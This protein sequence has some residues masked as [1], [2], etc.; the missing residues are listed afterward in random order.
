MIA[1]TVSVSGY[2]S[3]VS[4]PSKSLMILRNDH[5][6]LGGEFLSSRTPI[7]NQLLPDPGWFPEPIFGAFVMQ[8][9]LRLIIPPPVGKDNENNVLI[10]GLG[11][12][13]AANAMIRHN[14][15]TDVVELDPEVVR[16]AVEHFQL[17]IHRSRVVVCDARTFIHSLA[18]SLTVS[19]QQALEDGMREYDYIIHDIFTGGVMAPKLFTSEMWQDT[20][21]IMA[22]DGV[23]VVNFGGDL[24]S[25]M[26]RAMIRTLVHGFRQ[27]GG[28]CRAF[29]EFPKPK[30]WA[31]GE[32]DFAN[33]VVFCHKDRELI[34]FRVPVEQ[35]YLKSLV[36]HQSLVVKNEIE[37]PLYLRDREE[38]PDKRNEPRIIDDSNVH[39]FRKQ[40]AE[41]AAEHWE[42]MNEILDWS[43][44]ANW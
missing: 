3:V 22:P 17:P 28:N 7:V 4:I 44:W 24:E 18:R 33:V 30:N 20:R 36:R 16:F 19:P 29:R 35:D 23:L 12:G 13:T 10:V 9:S 1:S 2:L 5:S 27:A 8:E 37:L 40:A 41:G 42:L 26:S 6:L 21:N 25:S 32:K 39:R 38:T 31:S 14:I 34:R 43:V 11:I 15:S